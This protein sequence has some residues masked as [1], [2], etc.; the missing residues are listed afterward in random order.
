MIGS[1]SSN[2]N[3]N[4]IQQQQQQKI[5]QQ[6]QQQQQQ[7]TTTTRQLC[8][9]PPDPKYKSAQKILKQPSVSFKLFETSA[10]GENRPLL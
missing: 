2:N 3:I 8:N 10:T 4:K 9:V 7:N 5:Q 1:S 6:Q